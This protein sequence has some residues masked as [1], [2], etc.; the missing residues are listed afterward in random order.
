MEEVP[1]VSEGTRSTATVTAKTDYDYGTLTCTGS[2]SVGMQ[3]EPCVY[4]VI[5]AGRYLPL[6]PNSS[7]CLLLFMPL[8]GNP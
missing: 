7:E 6:P 5:T 2:N 4:T 8:L 3:R 1:F